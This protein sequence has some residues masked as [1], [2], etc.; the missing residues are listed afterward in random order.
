MTPTTGYTRTPFE[1]VDPFIG[2][3]GFGHTYPG[4]SLPFGMVQLSPDTRTSGWENCSGYHASNPTIIGFSHTHLSGTGAMDLGDILLA[5][6]TGALQLAAGDESDPAGGYRSAFRH[7]TETAVPGYYSVLLDDHG[8]RAELTVTERAGLHRYTFPRSPDSH[9]II[10]LQHGLG[11]RARSAEIQVTSDTEIAGFRRSSGWAE[12]HTVYFVA[13]FSKPFAACGTALDD[14]ANPQARRARG[15]N[16]KGFVTFSTKENEQI[17]VKVGISAVSIAGARKNLDTEI[18]GWEFDGVRAR[19]AAAWS[20]AL[21]AIRIESPAEDVRTVFYTAL[22]HAMLSPN[23]YTDVD[24]RYRG[25]D[26]RVHRATNGPIYTVFSLWDTFRATHPLYTIIEPDRDAAFIR[27]LLAKYDE[28]GYL[29]V[30]E[31]HANETNCMIGYHSV[32]V[33]V[34]AY[35]KGIRGFDVEKAF[36]AMKKSA[37]RDHRGLENYRALGYIPSNK[38]NESVS[39]TLEYAYDDWCIAEMARRLGRADDCA[40]YTRRA[41]SYANLLDLTTGFMRSKKDGNWEEPF[42]PNEV[43]TAYTEATAWQYRFFVPHDIDSLIAFAGGDLR[44]VET[45]DSVFT[46]SPEL[47][48]RNQ[49]DISGLIGQYA[50]G[51]EPS[52]HMAYLYN[53]AGAPWKTQERAREIMATLYKTGR[54]GLCGNEDCGQMSAW[55]VLSAMGFYPVCPGS[56]QYAI[57]TPIIEK[58]TI[59][60]GGGNTFT[61]VAKGLSDRNKYIQRAFLNGSPYT[62]SFLRHSDIVRGG[63]IVFELGDRPNPAWGSRKDDRPISVMSENFVMNPFFVAPSRSF[64]DSM[65]VEI[66]C[67]TPGAV[68]CY[69]TDGTRP[70]DRSQKYDGPVMLREKTTLRAIAERDGMEPSSVESVEYIRMPYRRTL[71]YDH[72]YHRA[73]TAGGD[74]GLV[75]GIRGDTASFA[76][77][78]GFLGVDLAATIDLGEERRIRMIS[79]GFLQDYGS[80]IFL[81]R[82]VEYEISTDGVSFRPIGTVKNPI[83]PDRDG[84]FVREFEKRIRHG[85]ARY[86]RVVARNI[87]VNPPGHPGAGEKAF[88]FADE[89]VIE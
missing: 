44:F 41:K 61:I 45:L 21:E 22:Y 18:P 70:T 46:A 57:G 48:G 38:Q 81:P 53:Y 7:E 73:Y 63:E 74:N 64:V 77:W 34:D 24:G 66:R 12:D 86:V 35:A 69:T 51:N 65:T 37:E 32:P 11:D 56:D 89:I 31:L 25:S 71:V 62:K 47:R 19:A 30:W 15:K 20:D 67:Y 87:G 80:W 29:P 33:I 28:S 1:S 4:A 42:D 88:I 83:P 49:P 39:K 23:L 72:P 16:V 26:G 75:D 68:I 76:E 60:V 58:A 85:K 2:T 78:Q 82:S 27:S 50:H 43:T 84:S 79:T 52:H 5:P 8:I 13:R 40:V 6:T 59:G 10:D 36:E 9:V 14:I 54:E 55:Y 3:G 17:L